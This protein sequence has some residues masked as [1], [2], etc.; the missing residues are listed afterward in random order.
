MER[1]VHLTR[2]IEAPDAALLSDA[3][4]R[5]AR[6]VPETH[7]PLRRLLDDPIARALAGLE[8]ADPTQQATLADQA[9]ASIA[10]AESGAALAPDW[11]AALEARA[12]ADDRQWWPIVAR[13][14]VLASEDR[15]RAART[16][17]SVQDLPYAFPGEI[18][19][20]QVDVFAAGDRVLPALH[21]DWA[22]KLTK[23]ACEAVSVDVR[24]LGLWA[25]PALQVMAARPL[26]QALRRIARRPRRLSPGSL[27][28]VVAYLEQLGVPSTA[29]L[30]GAD[31][32]ILDLARATRQHTHR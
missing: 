28:L 5:L 25:W 7:D 18:N 10:A 16:R 14:H 24:G 11:L 31:A 3:A 1:L 4:L 17:L 9:R 22:R 13:A 21:V 6:H 12:E 26:T 2:W 32:L 27:G 15:E 8:P 30:G 19:G 20:V 23:L 29:D